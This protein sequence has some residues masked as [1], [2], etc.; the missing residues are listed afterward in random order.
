MNSKFEAPLPVPFPASIGLVKRA[1]LSNLRLEI[2]HGALPPDLHGHAFFVGPGGFID[3]PE[4][5]QTGLINPSHDG[6]PL[7]NGDPLVHRLDL[8]PQEI[9]LSSQ[10][11]RTPCFYTD[12]VSQPNDH[13]SAWR[14]YGYDNFGL[15]RLSFRLGFRNEVNTAVIPVR[16]S[17]AEGYRM[18]LTWDAGRPYEIDPLSLQIAT[19]IGY[20][21][22]WKEQI[23]LPVPFGLFTTPAHPA[24]APPSDKD[25]ND[26]KLFT[27]NYGKSIGTFLHP[28]IH[29]YVDA[30]VTKSET[31]MIGIIY[32]MISLIELLLSV[33][34]SLLSI[35]R[36]IEVVTPSWLSNTVKRVSGSLLV[37]LRDLLQSS[38]NGSAELSRQDVASEFF[39]LIAELLNREIRLTTPRDDQFEKTLNYL[40]GLTKLLRE[41]LGKADIMSDFVNLISWNGHQEKLQQWKVYVEGE[42]SNSSPRIMQTMHQ[43]GVTKD[44]VILMDTVF[45]LGLEQLLTSPAPDLPELER[46]I[47]NITDFRQSDK[48]RIYV[49]NRSE[50]LIDRDS[51]SAKMIVLPRSAAHFLVDYNNPP[52]QITLHCAHNT[53]W[54]AAEWVRTYD[55]FSSSKYPGLI[56]MATGSTDINIMARYVIDVEQKSIALS[57]TAVDSNKDLTWM[58][59]LYAFCMPDGVTPPDKIEDLFWNGWGSHA[60][61]LPDYIQSL[62]QAAEP[63]E[64]SAAT[65]QKIA[66]R[67]LPGTLVHLQT[68]TMTI[69]DEYTF[70]LGRFGNSVQFIPRPS[71]EPGSAD[72]YLL[73]I[74][75]GSDDPEHSEFWLFDAQALAKGPI[76]CLAHPSMKIGLTIHSTWVP[77]IQKRTAAYLVSVRKDYEERLNHIDRVNELKDLFEKHVYPH[78]EI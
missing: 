67:G 27:V 42:D 61:L 33:F 5:G 15:S 16:F 30:P 68:K 47:R 29:G 76:C 71:A 22:E 70:P 41:L 37:S 72:G 58:L 50:L 77:S 36:W 9:R 17:E 40:I 53:G 75:N 73:C 60:D 1:P 18:L 64:F 6:T 59:A 39:G 21:N 12:L 45:K 46:S 63:R 66:E 14:S 78:F 26:S 69:V 3:T 4:C 49:I 34:R 65:A 25:A 24:F 20:N 62:N 43:I 10:I 57:E 2:R 35:L 51:V 54:D 23:Q 19:A 74:V 11:P 28:V 13:D 52:G 32:K 38:D 48:S 44:Y 56:G 31:E 7:F 55:Q 8:N